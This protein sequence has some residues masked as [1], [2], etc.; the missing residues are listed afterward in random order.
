MLV[1]GPPLE[2]LVRRLSECPPEILETCM[3]PAGGLQVG[4]VIADSLRAAGK[5]GLEADELAWLEWLKTCGRDRGQAVRYWGLLG[6]CVWLINDEWFCKQP[7]LARLRWQWLTSEAQMPL[8][9]LVRPDLYVSDPDRREELARLCLRALGLRP[10]GESEAQALDRLQTL[11][12]L[13]RHKILAATAEAERRAREVR[14][15]MA[16]KRALESAS[17]YGE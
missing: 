8:A 14:E 4:A 5:I 12:S 15:A 6:V 17:R 13:E 2:R 9:D 1:E 10:Q 7:E 11:D 3:V 16:R